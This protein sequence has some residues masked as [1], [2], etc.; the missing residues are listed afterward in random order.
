MAYLPGGPIFARGAHG[1]SARER[2]SPLADAPARAKG[3]R[4]LLA[5]PRRFRLEAFGGAHDGDADVQP[6]GGRSIPKG[7]IRGRPHR[8]GRERRER[9]PHLSGSGRPLARA[10]RRLARRARGF[11]GKSPARPGIL[12]PSPGDARAP[13][14]QPGTLRHRLDGGALRSLPPH[15][16]KHRQSAPRRRN[17]RNRG[18]A[19]QHLARPLRE[20]VLRARRAI[21]GEPR[22]SPPPPCRPSARR[23]AAFCAPTSRGS[24]RCSTPRACAARWPRWMIAII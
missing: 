14:A 5:L 24:A 9:R 17:A 11:S 21:V 10:Q 8:S 19:R 4:T 23:A 22:R 6:K 20:P 1:E 15:R 2:L 16:A 12:R 18:A 7:E 13:R 3:A